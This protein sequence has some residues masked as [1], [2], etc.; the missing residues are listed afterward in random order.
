MGK[1]I[2]NIRFGILAVLGAALFVLTSKLHISLWYILAVG[3]VSGVIF[4]KVF[5][6]WVCPIG[7]I[8]ELMMAGVGNDKFRQMYMYHKVGCPIAWVT[9][10]LN[11]FSLF[12]IKNESEECK[13][14]GICDKKCY[15]VAMEPEK[16]SLYRA[17]MQKPGDSY[18]CSRC[19]LCVAACPAGSL[20]YG[21]KR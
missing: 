18:I 3:A 12:K 1:F 15:V 14:C 6:R 16:Y 11:K 9:G 13:E 17:G 20:K 7:L 19:L 5:C 4:G 10:F 8:M 2:I 21:V